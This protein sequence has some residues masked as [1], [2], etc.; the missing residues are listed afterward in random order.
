MIVSCFIYNDETLKRRFCQS[1]PEHLSQIFLCVRRGRRFPE[2]VP[3]ST[4]TATGPGAARF[5]ARRAYHQTDRGQLLLRNSQHSC[6]RRRG[7]RNSTAS[8]AAAPLRRMTVKTLPNNGLRV[9]RQKLASFCRE[10]RKLLLRQGL[11]ISRTIRPQTDFAG[12]CESRS[13]KAVCAVRCPG[14]FVI[15]SIYRPQLMQEQI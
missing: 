1:L 15:G 13:H 3:S 4:P 9:S 11:T 2:V 8:C 12:A 14:W 5:V 6:E 10:T 7:F